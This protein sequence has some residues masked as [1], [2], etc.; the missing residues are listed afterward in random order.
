MTPVDDPDERSPAERRFADFSRARFRAREARLQREGEQ[1][2]QRE[3]E[4]R[5]AAV[6]IDPV[7]AALARA[8]AKRPPG[9]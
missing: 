1:R 8:R 5:R 9:E 4:Q 6:A 3:A 2:V 7:A